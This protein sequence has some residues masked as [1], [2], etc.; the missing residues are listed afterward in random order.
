MIEG[1]VEVGNGSARFGVAVR[2]ESIWQATDTVKA[3]YPGADNST[4][5][6]CL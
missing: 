6:T 1:R 4:C 5:R 2:A 3:Y